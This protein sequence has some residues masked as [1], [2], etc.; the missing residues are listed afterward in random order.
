MSR[1]LYAI[2]NAFGSD[3]IRVFSGDIGL[4]LP[5][6]EIL[7]EDAM[8]W[9]GSYSAGATFPPI[10]SLRDIET[11]GIFTIAAISSQPQ[12]KDY[13]HKDGT[14]GTM[15]V[16]ALR[17]SSGEKDLVVWSDT[18]SN[19]IKGRFVDGDVVLIAGVK[20]PNRRSSSITLADRFVVLPSPNGLE[21]EMV[22]D[23]EKEVFW[24]LDTLEDV[25]DSVVDIKGV[26]THVGEVR[27]FHRKGGGEGKVM[28]IEVFDSTALGTIT[29]WEPSEEILEKLVASEERIFRNLKVREYRGEV[30]LN[31]TYRTR[32]E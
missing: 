14:T 9:L 30:G 20:L 2:A 4:E 8:A 16:V 27:N 3:E 22:L 24:P 11:D 28:N 18:I 21:K 23:P 26:I 6:S 15:M 29:F 17:D 31:S 7:N 10:S 32:I 1:L 19:S 13:S 12:F 25:L 5:Y